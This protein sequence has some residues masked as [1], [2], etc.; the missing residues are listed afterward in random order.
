MG[1]LRA[2]VVTKKRSVGSCSFQRGL[3]TTTFILPELAYD[4]GDLEPAISGEI[5]K[6]HHQTYITNYNK[7]LDQLDAAIS[8][9]DSNAIAKL[10]TALRFNDGGHINHS[11]FWRNLSPVQEGGGT[12]L[13]GSGWVWLGLDKELK[14]LV[15]ET[16]ANQDPLVSIGA[17]LTPLLGID[18]STSFI[19]QCQS[20]Y[21]LY[22]YYECDTHRRTAGMHGCQLI[23]DLY[24]F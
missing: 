14:R 4:Y 9:S 20:L 18:V 8:K 23:A 21:P 16:T 19:T 24:R 10:H 13:Q 3:Q 1:V 2:L 5:M 7:A 11:I 22:I 6:L 12:A 17:N 15:V